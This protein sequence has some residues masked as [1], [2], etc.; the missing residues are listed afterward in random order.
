M[1]Y[2]QHFKDMIKERSIQPAWIE[3]TLNDPEKVNDKSDGTRHFLRRIPEHGNRWLRIV[4]NV[5]SKP[6]K[7]ITVFFDRGVKG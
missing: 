7:A 2:T 5:Q 6:N 1:E 4:V 3:L